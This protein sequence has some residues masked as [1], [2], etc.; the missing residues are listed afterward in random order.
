MFKAFNR[1]FSNLFKNKSISNTSKG[2]QNESGEKKKNKS[3]KKLEDFN[4]TMF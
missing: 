3:K 4:Y 1:Y 2:I